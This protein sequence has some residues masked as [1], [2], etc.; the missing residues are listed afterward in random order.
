MLMEFWNN[1]SLMKRLYDR[2]MDPVAEQYGITRME[3]DVLL[4]LAN[5]PGFDTAADM[6]ERRQLTKSH[7]SS[8]VKDLAERGCLERSYQDG[9]HK[10][11]HLKVLPAAEKIVAAGHQAQREFAEAIFRGFTE[12]DK[13]R[14][15]EFQQRMADNIRLAIRERT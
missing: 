13:E 4:F 7:V 15:G 3:L 10:L 8:S 11:I 6:I 1:T 2:I 5:N 12:E 9:N 14:M